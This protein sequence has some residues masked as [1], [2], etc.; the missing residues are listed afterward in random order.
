MT[1]VTGPADRKPKPA[2]DNDHAGGD[3]SSSVTALVALARKHAEFFPD[4]NKTIWGALTCQHSGSGTYVEVHPVD[5]TSFRDWLGQRVYASTGDTISK[6]ALDRVIELLRAG[7]RFGGSEPRV[8][9]LRTAKV[10]DTYYL[11]MCDDRWRVIEIDALGWRL[12][13]KSPVMFRR[14]PSMRALPDPVRGGRFSDVLDVINVPKHS[15]LLVLVW[16]IECLRP[17][18]PYVGLQLHGVEGSAKS[19]TQSI[20]R[21]LIDPSSENL[22]AKPGSQEALFVAAQQNLLISYEN[23]SGMSS[24]LQDVMCTMLTGGGFATRVLYSNDQ[25]SLVSLK[26]PVALN[27]INPVVTSPDLLDRFVCIELPVIKRRKTEAKLKAD[28]Q[29]KHALILGAVLKWFSKAL[30]ALPRV[31]IDDASAPRM[32]DFAKLGEAVSQAIGREPGHFLAVYA[33]QRSE[34]VK[35]VIDNT[36]FG[37]A[38]V[39]FM[40]PNREA[41]T[42]THSEICKVLHR[43]Y[44][45]TASNDAKRGA[46]PI[47]GKA[48][49]NE[50]R[51]LQPALGKIGIVVRRGS[52]VSDGYTWSIR[53]AAQPLASATRRQR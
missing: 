27:G 20:L 52:R 32:I 21:D 48:F 43:H 50:I 1:E 36:V 5:S 22:R 3:S 15:W 10:G 39:A 13:D 28:F 31:Q 49:G 26:R 44:A 24:D 2:D 11:D 25:E 46:W 23:L 12:L 29:V 35:Q 41:L 16:V 17:D 7:G 37:A 19:S 34:D 9:Y 18:T 42:G 4:P 8:V 47:G 30:A 45:G 53:R 40:T 6:G 51:R 14:S 38:I 33:A